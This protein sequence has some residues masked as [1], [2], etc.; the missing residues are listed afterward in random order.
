MALRGRGRGLPDWTREIKYP[1]VLSPKQKLWTAL[2]ECQNIYPFGFVATEVYTIPTGYKLVL[3]KLV[4]SMTG[5][6]GMPLNAWSKIEVKFITYPTDEAHIL[7]TTF[8]LGSG[9][10]TFVPSQELKEEEILH[11]AVWN[12]SSEYASAIINV[13]GVLE[14]LRGG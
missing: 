7:L 12:N 5:E 14:S 3:K 11:I 2:I 8:F 4:Y 10:H 9:A 6:H 1:T 13:V